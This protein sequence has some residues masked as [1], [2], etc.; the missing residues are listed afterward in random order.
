MKLSTLAKAAALIAIPMVAFST[1]ADAQSGEWEV[2]HDWGRLPDGLEWGTTSAIDTTPEGNIAL[3]RR[4]PPY[5]FILNPE[6]ELLDTWAEEDGMFPGAHGLK[7]DRDGFFW[8][9]DNADNYVKKFTPDGELVMTLG[10]PGE[11][12]DNNSEVAFDGPADVTIAPNGDLYVADGYRNSRVVQLSAEG[13][14]IRRFGGTLGAADGEF[15]LPHAVELD[16]EGRL[17]VADAENGRLQVFDDRANVAGVWTDFPANPRGGMYITSDDT[18]YIS[19]VDSE[20][21]TIMRDGQVVDTITGIEGRPHGVTVG[22]DGSVY[23]AN[24]GNQTVKKVV[25][26]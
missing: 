20:S 10:Q 23:V 4:T 15:N 18:L 5:V 6:G 14:F 21:V 9:T 12:G 24:P 22:L 17:I 19:H 2:I 26:R 1:L 11:A 3:L 8:I 7:I 13:V 25:R 16:S